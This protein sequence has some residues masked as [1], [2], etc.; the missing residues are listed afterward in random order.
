VYL[1]KGSQ[2]VRK[3]RDAECV[4]NVIDVTDDAMTATTSCKGLGKCPRH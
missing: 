1:S 4:M 3:K 2:I